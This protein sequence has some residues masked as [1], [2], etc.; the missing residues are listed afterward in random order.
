MMCIPMYILY[1]V[2]FILLCRTT[3][4]ILLNYAIQTKRAVTTSWKQ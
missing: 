3:V 1:K 4:Y 2:Y